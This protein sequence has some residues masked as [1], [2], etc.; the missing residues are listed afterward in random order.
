MK[1]NTGTFVIILIIAFLIG[2]WIVNAAFLGVVTLL[3]VIALVE[4][5]KP[6]KWLV[7]RSTAGI[8][9]FFQVIVILATMHYGLNITASL[10]I[11]SLGFSLMYAPRLRKERVEDKVLTQKE[12][13]Q[14]INN[15]KSKYSFK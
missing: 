8:D 7:K 4:G 11:A 13:A 10:T 6:L 14:S 9:I 15:Q 3:G 12:V 2:G 1:L 5:V